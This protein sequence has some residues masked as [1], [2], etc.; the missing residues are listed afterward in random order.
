M[1]ASTSTHVL[2]IANETVI[3]TTRE[4]TYEPN[5]DRQSNGIT[6][7]LPLTTSPPV[8]NG[9]L[10]IEKPISDNVLCPPK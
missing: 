1:D 5:L 4:K 2:M 6:Y 7:N 10:Q 3:M 9:S 8:S